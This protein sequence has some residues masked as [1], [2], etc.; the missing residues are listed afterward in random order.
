VSLTQ[1]P[2]MAAIML[3]GMLLMALAF[4]FYTV[5]LVLYR[6]R[7]LILQRESHATWVQQLDEVHA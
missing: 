4:W 6:V 5:A 1:A 3:W 2:S 7:T